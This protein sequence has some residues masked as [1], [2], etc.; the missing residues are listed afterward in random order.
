MGPGGAGRQLGWGGGGKAEHTSALTVLLSPPEAL[1]VLDLPLRFP[2]SL[3]AD[4]HDGD[5][6]RRQRATVRQPAIEVLEA[7]P[8]TAM[9][10]Q[11][12]VPINDFEHHALRDIIHENHCR[13]PAIVAPRDAAK[14]LLP[15]R[16]PY[17]QLERLVRYPERAR[18]ELDADGVRG[19]LLD[20]EIRTARI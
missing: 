11:P 8:S 18:V 16:V 5:M 12:S 19:L 14:P 15:R 10:R 7:G 3:I 2:I 1:A 6:G 4:Q 20:C 9:P 17:L 13:C